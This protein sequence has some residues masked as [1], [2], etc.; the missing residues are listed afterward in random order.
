M[1]IGID[2][3]MYSTEFTGIGRYVFELARNLAKVDKKNEYVLFMNKPEYDAYEPP[4]K[5][6]SKVLVNAKHYSYAEQIRYPSILRKAKLDLMHFTHFNAPM[7]YRRPSLVTIHDLT[8]S[9]FPGKKMNSGFQRFSYNKVLRS[10]LKH[11]KKIIAV[12]ENTKMDLEEVAGAFPDKIEVIYEGVN[13]NFGP[14]GVKEENEGVLKKYGITKNYLLYT[15]V[16]RGHKNLVNLIKAFSILHQDETFD[17]QLVI[18]GADDPY[19]P[20]IKRTVKELELE[21]NTIFTGLVSEEELVALYQEA[22]VF[23]FPSLYEGFGLPP[24]EAMRCG[25]PV[26]ASKTSCIPEVCGEDNALFFDPYDPT[27]MAD[28]I[29]K[30]WINEEL[31]G[32][33]RDRGLKW[34]KKFSWEKMAEK[35]LSVYE[36]LDITKKKK[37]KSRR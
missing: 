34:S 28:S 22:R 13:E 25:T 4:N 9:F 23:V 1:R 18:T 24:L 37:R 15:G 30:I 6:F 32:E 36:G 27:E 17:A 12:S 14:R 26:A 11:S 19:Y 5:R 33:L 29:N 21:N 7:L 16:W 2:A 35:T 20:E 10:I 3:R 31:R 8:L